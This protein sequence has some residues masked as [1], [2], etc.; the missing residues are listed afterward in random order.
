MSADLQRTSEAEAGYCQAIKLRD[1][2]DKHHGPLYIVDQIASIALAL[3]YLNCS[4]VHIN[5]NTP[6]NELKLMK[7]ASLLERVDKEEFIPRRTMV[8]FNMAKSV[9][10]FKQNKLYEA[11]HHA[12]NAVCLSSQ[13]GLG[14]NLQRTPG[15]LLQYLCD[16][17]KTSNELDLVATC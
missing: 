15:Q 2:V 13:C 11:I 7:A 16:F 12:N 3:V 5:L 6:V 14:G 9:L 8:E 4:F 1:S 10:C 17:R